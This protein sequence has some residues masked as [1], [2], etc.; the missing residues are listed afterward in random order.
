MRAFTC[1]EMVRLRVHTF[2]LHSMQLQ[3]IVDRVRKVSCSFACLINEVNFIGVL[4]IT[5]EKCF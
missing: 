4:A 5:Q 1:V 3:V 2:I